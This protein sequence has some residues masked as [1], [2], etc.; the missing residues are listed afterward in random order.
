MTS[1]L[2]KDVQKHVVTFGDYGFAS[3]SGNPPLFTIAGKRIIYNVSPGQPVAYVVEN[4][5]TRIINAAAPGA[6]DIY[7]LFVG[8]GVDETGSGITTSIRHLGIEHI[9][10][11]QPK[12]VSTSSPRCGAPQI[13]DFYFE[14]TKCNETYSVELKVDDNQSRSFS[15][16]NKSFQ[17]FIGTI[18]TSCSSCDDCDVEHNCREVACKLAD[19]LNGDLEIKIGNDS[20]PDFKGKGVPRPFYATRL[21][22]TSKT[23]CFAPQSVAN[24][25][26]SCTY[27]AAVKGAQIRD[28]RYNFVGNTNPADST[29]TLM[30]QI[31]GIVDQINDAF[32]TEYGDYAHAGSAYSTGSYSDCCPEQIHINTCDAS[33]TLYDAN[34]VA[35]TPSVVNNPFTEYGTT[36]ASATCVDCDDLSVA[37]SGTLT[38]SGGNA[39]DTQTV[40]ING[41]TYTF[42][43]TLTNV[44]GNVKVGATVADSITNLVA[45]INLTSGAGT[46]YAAA[47]TAHTTVTAV[48]GAGT[49]VVVTANTAGTA[50][51]AYATT[52][53]L[54][55]ASWADVTL[56]GGVAAAASVDTEYDCGIRVIAERIKGDCSCYINQPLA[57]YGRKITINPIG[58]AWRNK[59]WKVVE[60]QEMELP[61]GFGAW[62]QWLELQN[63]PG[64]RGRN[65]SRSNNLR[66][67]FNLPDKKSRMV[68]AVTADCK[69]NYCSYYL[70]SKLDT[71]QLSG[72]T[73]ELTIHSTIHIPAGDSTTIAAWE[74]FETALL[75]LNP[76]CKS[77]TSVACDTAL[78]SC[79]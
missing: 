62:I 43:D 30:A 70:K 35:I 34:F 42:Q 16:W 59:P 28:T 66:G 8:V 4:G 13:V 55:N 25:C 12:E 23:Y 36:S 72:K 19:A 41:K 20:Y 56:T 69:E 1:T 44:N 3:H 7:N 49:T 39:I 51:N 63:E 53:T 57:F 27:V 68:K 54:T 17:Q 31:A 14:C 24:S 67:T 40:T 9:S 46:K 21:H 15:P 73:G 22:P 18:V 29:Q 76:Q 10:G 75:A 77:L 50:G 61:A 52:D 65:Y 78:A 6:S 47:M 58:D 48:D 64:G 60:V 45:A 33:F 32:K 38:F 79:S 74:A 71:N 5:V 11:C 2:K 26:T 37:A